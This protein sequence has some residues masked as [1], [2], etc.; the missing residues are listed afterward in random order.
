MMLP[1]IKTA[2]AK[3]RPLTDRQLSG[4]IFMAKA[5]IVDDDPFFCELMKDLLVQ[6]GLDCESEASLKGGLREVR[7]QPYD[8][9]FLDVKLPDGNGLQRLK[10]FQDAP[11]S[12][13]VIILTGNADSDGAE[14][15]IKTGAWDYVQKPASPSSIEML[16]KR[17]I[18]FREKKGANLKEG[19]DRG[20][21]IGDSPAMQACLQSL[22]QAAQTNT[23]VLITGETGTGKEL[24]AR[25]IHDNGTRSGKNFVIVDCTSIPTT[26]AESLL[27][28]HAKGSF[29]DA[30]ETRE[31]LI[32][33]ADTGTLFLDELGDLDLS[34]QKSLLR[35]LQDHKYRPIG[36]RKELSSD[37][38]LIAAT[39]RN[40]EAMVEAGTF[41]K[42]LFYRLSTFTIS[43]PPLRVRMEDIGPLADYFVPRLC[44]ESGSKIKKISKDFY[45]SL[46]KYNWP[47]NIREFI[48]VLLNSVTNAAG[49][50]M[51]HPYHLPI[52]L[53][54]AIAKRAFDP[55]EE[56]LPEGD[57]LEG[58]LRREVLQYEGFPSFKHFRQ[59][60]Q[61]HAEKAYLKE[62][63]RI[64][65]GDPKTA[66]SQ[67]GLSRAR[68]YELLKKHS[69]QLKR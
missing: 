55:A 64:C 9:V 68:L 27:F 5:L 67:S 11:S 51:L 6:I 52:D 53:R 26:L 28:G 35:V 61:E 31:G 21:I 69:L 25:A 34:V 22:A 60:A 16:V 44:K 17:A 39:N 47:G 18:R 57:S 2:C 56:S 15:A 1:I 8:L 40:L 63:A 12:P 58:T 30:H 20:S 32:T 48:N 10:D 43:L 14:L 3:V 29:T 33:Q 37:F 50:N 49:E 66:C 7:N 59:L 23:N 13:E 38:R 42:D 24:F 54:A 36:S 65:K 4:G 46:L 41:R 45:E 19:L 62:L